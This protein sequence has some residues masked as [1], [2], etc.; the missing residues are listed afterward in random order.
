MVCILN[1]GVIRY[2]MVVVWMVKLVD[3]L[4]LKFVGGNFM[5]V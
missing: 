1:L 5:L 4:D 3:V 2:F